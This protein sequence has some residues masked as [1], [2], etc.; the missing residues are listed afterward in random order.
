MFLA[1]GLYALSGPIEM[2][3][4]LGVDVSGPHALIETKGVYG[5]ISL[6]AA[7]LL[8]VAVFR[9]SLAGPA[10]WFITVY[11]GGYLIGRGASLATDGMPQPDF[12][13]F[14]AF[15]AIVLIGALYFLMSGRG[16]RA[17]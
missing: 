6:G 14:I 5:G 10:L 13:S 4:G 17:A 2:L 9:S 8:L 11:M 3:S 12:W 15:E 1:F 16:L 7:T